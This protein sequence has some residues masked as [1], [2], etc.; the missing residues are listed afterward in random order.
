MPITSFVI[1]GGVLMVLVELVFP[2][3]NVYLGILENFFLNYSFRL[4]NF[5]DSSIEFY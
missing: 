5:T 3:L 1:Y 2:S 4:L